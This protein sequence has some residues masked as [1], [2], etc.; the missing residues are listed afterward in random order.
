MSKYQTRSMRTMVLL[1][2]FVVALAAAVTAF[3]Q[4]SGIEITPTVGYRWGGTILKEDNPSL[5]YDADLSDDSSYGIVFDFP[6]NH[7]LQIEL[8]ADHQSTGLRR[9]QLFQPS[10]HAFDIDVNYYHIG[11]LGQWPTPH[12]VPFVS[13]GFG[14]AD[15][16]PDSATLSNSRRF[17]ATLG[18]GIKVPMGEHVGF[19]LEGRGY[20]SDTSKSDWEWDDC[21]HDHDNCGWRHSDLAQA[22]IRVGLVL[23]F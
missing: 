23:K 21:N 17:S 10:D 12:V 15:L 7:H 3:G 14:V 4:E 13:G 5:G 6:I 9:D 20:W 8:S 18:A 11:V 19:R 16:R 2:T 1:T 22:Q